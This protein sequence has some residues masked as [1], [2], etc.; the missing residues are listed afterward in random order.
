MPKTA[1]F[2]REDARRFYDRFGMKQDRQGFYEDRALDLLIEHGAFSAARSVLEIGCGTGRLA[3]RLLSDHLPASARYV[4]VDISET[5]VG[6]AAGRLERWGDRAEV[7]VSVGDFD[8]S[9]YGA[10]FDRVVGTYVF[11]LLSPEDIARALSGAHAATRPG[12]F[13]CVAGLT[14]GTGVLSRATSTVWTWLHGMNPSLVGGC[15]PLAL[16]AF[17]DGARWRIAYR[18][19]VV[20]ATVPS[21]VIL[22]EA[23]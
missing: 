12:G 20:S 21:E 17:I 18:E 15:R 2:S 8:F 10:A 23:L 6:L 16:S 14:Q 22:A 13:L 4:G 9:A 3:A 5:M 1:R 19:V 7:R 11:D